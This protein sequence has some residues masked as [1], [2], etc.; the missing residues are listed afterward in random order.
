MPTCPRQGYK[1]YKWSK[2][3]KWSKG[4][5][6]SKG[7]KGFKWSSEFFQ[8]NIYLPRVTPLATQSFKKTEC[9]YTKYSMEENK[10][11]PQMWSYKAKKEFIG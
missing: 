3:S 7:Y 9:R 4:S 2:W 10:I 11:F 6:R 5:K 8:L 1:W